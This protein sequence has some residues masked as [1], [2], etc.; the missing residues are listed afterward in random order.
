M[1]ALYLILIC[2][3]LVSCE[4]APK[5]IEYGSDNCQYCKMTIVDRQHASEIVTEKGRAYKFDA[6]EC[7][8]NYDKEYLDQPVAMYLVSDFDDPGELIDATTATYLISPKISSPM[9]ANLSAFNSREAANRAKTEFGGETYS[10]ESTKK[11]LKK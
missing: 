1:K 7:M 8:I 9:N 11:Q 2:A 6:I 5:P 10:W 3:L 4:I